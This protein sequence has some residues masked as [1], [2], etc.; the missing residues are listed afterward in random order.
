MRTSFLLAALVAIVFSQTLTAQQ[1]EGPWKGSISIMGQQLAIQVTFAPQGDSL[2]ATI[3]IPQQAAMKLPLRSVRYTHPNI[4]FDLPAG[5]TVASFEGTRSGDSISGRFTQSGYT[6]TFALTPGAL[7]TDEPDDTTAPPY[8]SEEVTFKNGDGVLAGT[9]TLPEGEGPHPAVVLVTGSGAQNR[10]EEIF[11]FKPFRIIA[12]HLTRSGIAVL[13]YD[14]R[15][16]GGSTGAS[17]DQTTNDFAADA[18]VAVST[19][20]D[21]PDIDAGRIGILG[22]SEG[23]IVAPIAAMMP[24]VS[25]IVML[26]APAWPGDTIIMSQ[27]ETLMRAGGADSTTIA[28]T[29]TTQR[30]FYAALRT[31]TGWE[32]VRARMREDMLTN[33]DSMPAEA[34]AMITNV[35]STVDARIEVQLSASR[36]GWFRH[37]IDFDPTSVLR[38][39]RVPV[40]ALF[41]E[42]DV[43]VPAKMNMQRMK[44][45]F[46]KGGV[47]DFTIKVIPSANHL[48]Q[49]AEKGT[50]DEYAMLPKRF[51]PGVLET[52]SGWILEKTKQ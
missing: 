14:D 52:I 42:K 49:V 22:H 9:L 17:P 18:L 31:G 43:Q 32:E 13:R 20:A 47:R 2:A 36:T 11:G 8:R 38:A 46:K 40:L 1:L 15:G 34:R 33:L 7:M 39:V 25:F 19:L 16:V 27:I 50:I 48:F 29:L 10:D 30:M 26:A 41:G 23:G 6:G 3:D 21:R 35:D 5:P 44:E 12:D 51:A 4:R 28:R 37:F 24:Q 45:A